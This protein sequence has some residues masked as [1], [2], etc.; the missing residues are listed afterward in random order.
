L[1]LSDLLEGCPARPG[2]VSAEAWLIRSQ[3]RER[4][5]VMRKFHVLIGALFAVFAI[6]AV[7]AASASALTE[8]WL[9]EG[10]NKGTTKVATE[11]EGKVELVQYT[12]TVTALPATVLNKISCEGTFDGFAWN[13]PSA[14][15]EITALLNLAKEEVKLGVRALL[16]DVTFKGTSLEDC[17]EGVANAEVYAVNLPWKTEVVLVGTMIVDLFTGTGGEP[18]YEVICQ[19]LLGISGENICTAPAAGTT[20]ALLE[21][22]ATTPASVAGFFDPA[23]TADGELA[24]CT[25][26]GNNVSEVVSPTAGHTWAVEGE[27]NHL[28]LAI[29]EE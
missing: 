14:L 24:N 8:V 23:E 19:S 20:K 15:D 10:V 3:V 13:E 29:S 9:V 4:Q 12:G 21:N 7:A 2:Q 1:V 28:A 6:G 16:C 5:I 18:G 22:A 27:L 11:A 26:G 25:L 17:R